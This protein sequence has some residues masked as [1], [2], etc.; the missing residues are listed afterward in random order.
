[1]ASK[2]DLQD[3]VLDALRSAGG[4]AP[5]VDVCKRIWNAHEEELRRSGDL[6]YTWQYDV[7]WAA[8]RLRRSGQLRPVDASPAGVW[9]LA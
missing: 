4:S 7:R 2:Y 6:F 5:L 9:E 8:H 1:L 3:W